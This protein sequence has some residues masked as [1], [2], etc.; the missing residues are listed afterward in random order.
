MKFKAVFLDFYGTLVHEDDRIIAGICE[1]IKT[2]AAVDCRARDIGG[3]WWNEFTNTFQ[4]SHGELFQTQRT[5]VLNSLEKTI[6]KFESS[7]VAGEM[8]QHQFDHWTK[9]ELFEDTQPFLEAL[10]GIP[11]YILSNIDASDIR[12]A[13]HYH[14]IQVTDVLSSEDVQAYKPRPELFVEALRRSHLSADEVIHIGDSITSDVE[15]A[16][17][18]GIQAVWLNRL[19]KPL[20]E[21]AKPDFIC[22]DLIEVRDLL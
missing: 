13:V 3:Y 10:H 4:Q 1:Q 6:V 21:G 18:I 9:P 15:G 7:C 17:S 22:K 20:P 5:L 12:E 16:Q 14:G 2:N 11:V 19:N 8:I